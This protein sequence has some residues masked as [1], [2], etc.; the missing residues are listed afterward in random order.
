[1]IH[2]ADTRPDLRALARAASRALSR[3]ADAPHTV[4]DD[5]SVHRATRALVEA[6]SLAAQA[7][8]NL[9]VES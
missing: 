8:R 6:R 3:I 2:S 1:M 9:G 5:E 7:A 4:T